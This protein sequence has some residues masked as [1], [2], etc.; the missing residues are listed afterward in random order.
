MLLLELQ[1]SRLKNLPSLEDVG[2]L[3]V[4]YNK[5][6]IMTGD[7][8]YFKKNPELLKLS[9]KVRYDYFRGLLDEVRWYFQNGIFQGNSKKE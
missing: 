6:D 9:P 2:L 7:K 5:L 4:E 1:R 8:K 3:R